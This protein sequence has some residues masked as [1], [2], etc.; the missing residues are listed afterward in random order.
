MAKHSLIQLDGP[1]EFR[2]R[3]GFRVELDDDVVAGLVFLDGVGQR[4][5][6]PVVDLGRLGAGLL[7][8]GIEAREALIDGGLFERTVRRYRPPRTDG[9]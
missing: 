1:L 4:A 7:D 6:A 5:L 2:K 3:G 8:Q 9:S